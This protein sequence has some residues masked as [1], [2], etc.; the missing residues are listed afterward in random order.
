MGV[1]PG[2]TAGRGSE[3]TARGNRFRHRWK[4][5]VTLRC[6]VEE[7]ANMSGHSR[8]RHDTHESRRLDHRHQ[9]NV[10]T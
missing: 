8:G 2:R 3:A 5:F 7:V 6:S 4:T 1:G 10:S 9:T